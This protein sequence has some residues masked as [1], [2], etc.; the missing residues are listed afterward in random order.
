M[1]PLLERIGEEQAILG[2]V[3]LFYQKI[4][5]DGSITHHFKN[6]DM[7]LQ[8]CKMAQ[9]LA[10]MAHK[11]KVEFYDYKLRLAHRH[12]RLSDADFDVALAY[13]MQSLEELGVVG[14]LQQEMM[15]LMQALRPEIVYEP[16]PELPQPRAIAMH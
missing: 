15:A 16:L 9:F 12:L 14:E 7:R 3:H 5:D 8:Q 11:E 6:S 13:F 4:L 2:A 10:K 1:K